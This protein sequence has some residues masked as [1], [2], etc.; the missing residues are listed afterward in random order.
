MPLVKFHL[1]AG[2]LLQDPGVRI[3]D[4]LV[5]LIE[6]PKENWSFGRGIATDAS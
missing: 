4:V 2:G 6:V 1:R 5:N 3:D